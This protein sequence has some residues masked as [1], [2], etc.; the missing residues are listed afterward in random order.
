MKHIVW[1]TMFLFAICVKAQINIT[2]YMPEELHQ[3]Y[4]SAIAVLEGKLNNILSSN[5]MMSQMG[6][7]RF[8]ITG[9]I[10]PETKDIV[11][12]APLQIAYTLNIILHIGDA[13]LGTKYVSD[14]FRVKGVGASDEKAYLAAIRSLQTKTPQ[15]TQFVIQ[16]KK[17]IIDFYEDNKNNLFS[18]VNSAV[19]NGNYDEA[20]YLLCLIPMECSF[21][22]EAQQKISSVYQDKI[23]R[24]NMQLFQEAKAIWGANQNEE[25]A[26]KIIS[27]ISQID[28][29]C[30]FF[31]EVDNFINT[32][33]SKINLINEREY[34]TYQK[35]LDHRNEME[36]L[37]LEASREKNRLETEVAKTKII[38]NADV[39]KTRL[40]TN[41]MNYAQEQKTQREKNYQNA[42]LESKAIAAYERLME[43]KISA[44]RDMAITYAQK[45]PRTMVYNIKNW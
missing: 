9:N 31:P 25:G 3:N 13:E 44:A 29:L 41:S 14:S 35:N 38:A 42:A 36:R 40:Q 5:N 34:T 23:D 21:Y 32:V 45:R 15:M 27:L 20:I 8:I 7:S 16:G 4:P 26:N 37:E 2:P 18:Q 11:S 19:T 24:E 10:V 1:I 22:S 12:S 17:R 28:P 33:N 30:S 6:N 39:E 43:K